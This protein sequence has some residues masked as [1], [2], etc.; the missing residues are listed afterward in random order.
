MSTAALNTANDGLNEMD[1]QWEVLK[2]YFI[3]HGKE[4]TIKKV[5]ND[6][7]VSLDL[8]YDV[9]KRVKEDVEA[10]EDNALLLC[11]E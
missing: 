3:I 6:M 7:E 4:A 10:D 5:M 1:I 11:A 9:V 8:A 2:D